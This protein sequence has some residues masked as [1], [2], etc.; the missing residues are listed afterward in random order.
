MA[1]YVLIAGGWHAG[2]YYQNLAEDL[3]KQNHEVYPLT[4][5]G[6][7]DRAHL[8]TSDTNLETHIQ[9]VIGF[10]KTE[11]LKD[12]ILCGHSYGGMVITGVADRIPE[13]IS[14]LVY[15]DAYVPE[16][17]DSCW[18]LTNEMYRQMFIDGSSQSGYAVIPPAGLD[19]RTTPH[20]FASF[21]QKIQLRDKSKKQIHQHYIYLSG[22]DETP[23]TS[24]YKRLL[25]DPA[26][27]VHNLPV[28]HNFMAED[29]DSMLSILLEV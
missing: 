13:C 1:V 5:T 18:S 7:G 4:L 24:T 16:D 22:W 28:G 3:R 27:S 14:N 29:P 11:Q 10:L 23:F 15:I 6:L 26:W 25:P 2:W 21:I 9:D 8:L 17:G 20:P 19:A 12:V